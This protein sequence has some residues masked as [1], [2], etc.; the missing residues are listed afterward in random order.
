[1]DQPQAAPKRRR[2]LEPNATRYG[3]PVSVRMDRDVVEQLDEIADD[4]RRSRNS[5]IREGADLVLAKHGAR[6]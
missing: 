2:Y 4:L 6:S 1:M 5:L 3:R